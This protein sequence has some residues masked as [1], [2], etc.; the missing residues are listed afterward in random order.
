M[1]DEKLFVTKRG[2]PLSF[3]GRTFTGVVTKMSS[4]KTVTIEWFRLFYLHKFER[5]ERRR[6]RIKAHKPD[7]IDV[8]IGDK[9]KIME[10]RPISKTK[11]FVILEVIK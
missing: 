9:V 10:T 5:F 7:W 8:S 6:S 4:Q 2:K 1:K 3:R 11:N